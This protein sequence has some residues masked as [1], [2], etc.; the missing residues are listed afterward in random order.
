VKFRLAIARAWAVVKNWGTSLY[1]GGK[2]WGTGRSTI[3]T[4]PPQDAR[5]D[6]TSEHRL[7]IVRKS[8]YFEANNGIVNR[9]VDVFEQFTVGTGLPLIPASSDPEWNKKASEWFNQWCEYCDLTSRQNFSTLQSLIARAWFIDGE[10]FILKTRGETR[11]DQPAFPRIQLIETHRVATPDARYVEEGRS[12]F[13]G[14]GTD[15]RG[16]P[17]TYFVRE[18]NRAGEEVV[19]PIAAENIIHVGEPSRPGM[20]RPLP[21]LYPVINDLHD[22]DD[23][24]L[25][26]MQAAK[27]NAS[28]TRTITNAASEIKSS[29]SLR[30]ESVTQ[31][32]QNSSGVDTEET[33][34][35]LWQKVLGARTIALK[36]GEELKEFRSERPSVAVREYWDYLTA[37][38]CAGVGISK[39]LVFP[40]SLQGT[41]ARAELDIASAFFRSRSSVLQA[42]FIEIY[43]YAMD[44]A[45]KNVRELADPPAD[46]RNVTVRPPRAPNVDVGR[47]SAAMLA[48]LDAAATNYDLIYGPLGLDA[49]VELRKSAEFA[50]YIRELATEF[51]VTPGEIRKSAG[52]VLALLAATE[53]AEQ[54]PDAEEVDP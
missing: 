20:L 49:R 54:E 37:K 43:R 44:W 32:N 28:V 46:W 11:P 13:D 36:T 18:R 50:A 8:R 40:Q 23:L 38:V 16:R 24:Q 51:K 47:N 3:V 6:C 10:I 22:L 31:T 19:S 17:T 4:A 2:R 14:I 5:F 1:E 35:R 7:E 39:L 33:R 29:A 30:R 15:W 48:E 27:D 52:E 42:A 41:V 26:E 34:T 9:L 53:K 21:F 25:L 12:I 45:I